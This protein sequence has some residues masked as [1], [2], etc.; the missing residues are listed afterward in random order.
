MQTILSDE[1]ILGQGK[2]R[3]QYELLLKR[4]LKSYKMIIRDV[5][6]NLNQKFYAMNKNIFYF[7][8]KIFTQNTSLFIVL[9]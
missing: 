4:Y 3:E 9:Y 1:A 2:N 7:A 6:D 8:I 5:A